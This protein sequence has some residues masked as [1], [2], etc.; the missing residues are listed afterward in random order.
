MFCTKPDEK[1]GSIE[2]LSFSYIELPPVTGETKPQK[3]YRITGTDGTKLITALFDVE[4]VESV[5]RKET[6]AAVFDSEGNLYFQ[7]DTNLVTPSIQHTKDKT[8]YPEWFKGVPADLEKIGENISGNFAVENLIVCAKAKKEIFGSKSLNFV[9]QYKSEGDT[10]LLRAMLWFPENGDNESFILIMPLRMYDYPTFPDKAKLKIMLG[11]SKAVKTLSGRVQEK[12]IKQVVKEINER[13]AEKKPRKV[14]KMDAWDASILAR[15][16]IA[17]NKR[18]LTLSQAISE[19]LSEVG[20]TSE[21]IRKIYA[22]NIDSFKAKNPAAKKPAAKKPAAK[23]PAAKKPATAEK[24]LFSESLI[25][26]KQYGFNAHKYIS[27]NFGSIA[28]FEEP[29]IYVSG[30]KESDGNG[31]GNHTAAQNA[32]YILGEMKEMFQDIKLEK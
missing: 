18:G 6:K 1:R 11:D 31:W 19:I 32:K 8:N 14:K 16:Q 27:E 28:R 7:K 9:P 30:S 2:A 15:L 12:P 5:L 26:A 22:G 13:R 23:K 25:S 21:Y 17:I 29:Y 20:S 3:A 4:S 24:R 10:K